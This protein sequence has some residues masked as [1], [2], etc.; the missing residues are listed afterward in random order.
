MGSVGLA[1]LRAVEERTDGADR[2]EDGRS[3]EGGWWVGF[4]L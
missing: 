1:K 2:L 4:V 3:E